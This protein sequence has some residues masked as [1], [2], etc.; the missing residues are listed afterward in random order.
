MEIAIVVVLLLA[1]AVVG[2]YDRYAVQRTYA[3]LF[4]E[5]HGHIPPL[6]DWFFRADPD[7]EVESWRRLHRNLWLLAGGLGVA[8]ILILIVRPVGP[9]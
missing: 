6:T 5:R 2:V 9:G 8:A 4:A 7:A 1:G 3:D